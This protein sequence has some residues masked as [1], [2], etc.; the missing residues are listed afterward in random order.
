MADPASPPLSPQPDVI[1]QPQGPHIDP[2]LQPDV[3]PAPSGPEVEQPGSPDV[4]PL[5][6]PPEVSPGTTGLPEV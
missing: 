6:S 5:D 4:G 2:P 1:P 3:T